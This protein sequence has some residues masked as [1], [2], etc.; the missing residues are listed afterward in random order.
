MGSDIG[1]RPVSWWD[2]TGQPAI[3]HLPELLKTT[4]LNAPEQFPEG[5]TVRGRYYG[6][7]KRRTA[8]PDGVKIWGIRKDYELREV[9]F[10]LVEWQGRLHVV[11]FPGND[12][13]RHSVLPGYFSPT[14][15]SSEK[16]VFH[17]DAE[18]GYFTHTKALW[19]DQEMQEVRLTFSTD[20]LTVDYH[21]PLIEIS[22]GA[23]SAYQ[24]TA[25]RAVAV[26]WPEKKKEVAFQRRWEKVA[27]RYEVNRGKY[28]GIEDVFGNEIISPRYRTVRPTQNN[29]F[30]LAERFNGTLVYFNSEGVE[31]PTDSAPLEK[32]PGANEYN[33]GYRLF[34]IGKY[35]K[36]LVDDE[37]RLVGP[38][39][40]TFSQAYFPDKKHVILSKLST[41]GSTFLVRL[42]NGKTIR[43][44][45]GNFQPEATP[46][47]HYLVRVF[48]GLTYVVDER[49]RLVLP[50]HYKA[51]API[52]LAQNEY[53][54]ITDSTGSRR[55]LQTDG[56]A[57]AINNYQRLE[58]VTANLF[59]A[60]TGEKKTL[61]NN[62]LQAVSDT[63]VSLSWRTNML[64]RG[65][66]TTTP[67]NYLFK[68]FDRNNGVLL[69]T[70]GQLLLPD[71]LLRVK[72]VT[73]DLIY[74]T[75]KDKT[76]HMYSLHEK[77][78]TPFPVQYFMGHARTLRSE[79][80]RSMLDNL[81]FRTPPDVPFSGVLLTMNND[82][83]VVN[84]DKL[85]SLAD[86]LRDGYA[87]DKYYL[88]L[89]KE[90]QFY[91]DT[92]GANK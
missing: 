28:V 63:F 65:K 66:E 89:L 78:I 17:T 68:Y 14:P 54:S 84:E 23:R 25:V 12:G 69:D 77:G 41:D 36:L 5:M 79:S 58:Q 18:T 80:W 38:I 3:N 2:S 33:K 45:P 87:A 13:Y 76:T 47:G 57:T 15:D 26:R 39:D 1:N 6:T 52:F 30:Y 8:Y 21:F 40:R 20:S 62:S 51:V 82:L 42:K 19:H 90:M 88:K 27:P 31:I 59:L 64:I 75:K 9:E 44:L 86:L 85:V 92:L 70:F 81:S 16:F 55:L 91:A 46:A 32:I 24:Q 7:E 83:F 10:F 49:L 34:A 71:T 4:D 72:M 53:Y 61:Y 56:K 11:R 74:L 60:G 48:N 37:N 73:S 50:S 22:S 29:D 35:H 67:T 43:S